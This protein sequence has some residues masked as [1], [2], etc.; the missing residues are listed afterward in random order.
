M[1]CE[2][3]TTQDYLTNILL[4]TLILFLVYIMYRRLLVVLGKNEAS[5]QF[6]HFQD[7]EVRLEEG[8][9]RVGIEV[10]DPCHVVVSI[11]EHE[12]GVQRVLFDGDLEAGE[13]LFDIA[14]DLSPGVYTCELRTKNQRAERYFTVT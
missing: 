13:H 1:P 12:N 2:M 8:A 5:R 6:V 10:P 4:I 14:N 9:W 3:K 11:L 7:T